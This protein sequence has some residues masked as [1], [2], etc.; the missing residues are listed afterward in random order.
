MQVKLFISTSHQRGHPTRLEDEVNAWLAQ[1]EPH[2]ISFAQTAVGNDL[3]LT[4]L[5]ENRVSTG[6]GAAEA[7]AASPEIPDAIGRSL[8]ETA[9]DPTSDSPL[10]PEAELPY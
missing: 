7:S 4:F 5:Y 10:L 6:Y 8:E 2:V 9:L 1:V 3:V